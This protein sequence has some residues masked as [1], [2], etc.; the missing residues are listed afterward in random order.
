MKHLVLILGMMASSFA[1]AADLAVAVGVRNT[2]ASAAAG[3]GYDIGAKSGLQGGILAF[4]PMT[5][6]L[7]VRSGF[8]YTNR[9]ISVT[10][11]GSNATP[12]DFS[13]WNFDIPATLMWS[14]SDF[15]GV[16]AGA[17]MSMNVSSDSSIA[18]MKPTSVENLIVPLTIGASFKFAP[19]LG[20]EMYFETLPGK[21]SQGIE[22]VKS[23][24]IQLLITFD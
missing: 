23:V 19:Q 3:T 5:N 15:G 16:Y 13:Y 24:G 2:S 4:L 10:T 9:S 14:F 6:A 12:A 22:S 1:L 7:K 8:L 21:I 18:G 17:I 20:A 11:A